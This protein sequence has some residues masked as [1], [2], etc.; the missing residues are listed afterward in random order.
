MNAHLVVLVDNED[1]A[2]L[3]LAHLL[4][5]CPHGSAYDEIIETI[6][7]EITGSDRVAEVA[8]NLVTSQTAQI[9]QVGVVDEHLRK[10]AHKRI[11]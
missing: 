5:V 3:V 8:A 9:G 4:V 11:T 2:G 1:P 7:V 10:Y 6:T